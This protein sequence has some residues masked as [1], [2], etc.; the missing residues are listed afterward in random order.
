IVSTS[1]KETNPY[2]Q[3]WLLV[4]VKLSTVEMCMMP[5]ATAAWSWN[6][7]VSLPEVKV[8]DNAPLH[9]WFA[10]P[11]SMQASGWICV[12]PPAKPIAALAAKERAK[13]LKVIHP[14]S[15]DCYRDVRTI[16]R[17]A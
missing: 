4:T 17:T 9:F 11:K 12:I 16:A 6:V 15:Y 1:W 2:D 10:V 7:I 5:I 13:V 8:P 14:P 3:A